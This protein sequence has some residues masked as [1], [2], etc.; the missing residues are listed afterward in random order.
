MQIVIRTCCTSKVYGVLLSM[1]LGI[2]IKPELLLSI[3][4]LF[5]R[6]HSSTSSRNIK[7]HV[8]GQTFWNNMYKLSCSSLQ[9]QIQP[10]HKW[11]MHLGILAILL[12]GSFPAFG[13]W[14]FLSFLSVSLML[15][16][17]VIFYFCIF[18]LYLYCQCQC[19]EKAKNQKPKRLIGLFKSC[20]NQP[21]HC[22]H[23][24]NSSRNSHGRIAV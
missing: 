8:L 5:R 14:R 4:G 2:M 1:V 21:S 7:I 11:T 20:L 22:L 6:I 10:E 19:R 9:I 17:F 13:G 23:S 12:C 18:L 3:I 16:V 15:C 24:S